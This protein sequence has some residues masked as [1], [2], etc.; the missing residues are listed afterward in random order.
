MGIFGRSH[1]SLNVDLH[2][3]LIPNIDD[4]YQSLEQSIEMI[5]ALMKLGFKKV[6][7]TPHIHPNYPN[8]PEI[9]RMGLEKLHK[10]L[11]KQN[12]EMEVEVAAEY[13]VDEAFHQKVKNKDALLSFGGKHVLVESSFINK[14]IFFESAMF[15]LQAAGYTPVLAHPERYRFLEGR[16]DWLEELKNMGV[17][18]QVTLGSIAG[19]YGKI[20]EQLGKMLIKK[21]LADFLGSDLHRKSHLAFLNKGLRSKEVQRA[22]KGNSIK[23]QQLL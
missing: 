10:A 14:P 22:L 16:I 19:Y 11:V 2:S 6:I 5:T 13:F 8:T 4:G 17:L 1:A 20:P 15:D 21:E 9:I 7:T 12:L 18:F 3:H 23:N